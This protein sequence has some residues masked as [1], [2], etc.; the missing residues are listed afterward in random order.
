VLPGWDAAKWADPNHQT[1]KY[2][3]GR[4]VS[5]YGADDAGF[6]KAVAEIQKAYPGTTTDGKDKVTIPGVGT[7][8]IRTEASSGGTGWAWQPLTNPDGSSVEQASAPSGSSGGG[9]NNAWAA[10][11]ANFT[12]RSLIQ[13]L[14]EELALGSA[15]R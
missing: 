14:M 7:I 1:P 10:G 12:T 9:W 3:V 11:G 15:L 6:A 8:D 5:Q 13:K 4:I 2:V